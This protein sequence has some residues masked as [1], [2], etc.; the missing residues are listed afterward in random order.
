MRKHSHWPIDQEPDMDKN[1]QPGSSLRSFG[2]EDPNIIDK[3]FSHGVDIVEN[4][5]SGETKP[6]L[7]STLCENRT[8]INIQFRISVTCWVRE[9]QG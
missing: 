2:K 5:L 1:S 3:Y 7:D 9:W 6:R 4:H 8:P